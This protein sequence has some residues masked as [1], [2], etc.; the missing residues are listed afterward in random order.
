M[1]RGKRDA[2]KMKEKELRLALVFYG[3]VSLAIYQHG[4]NIEILN[5]IR[6]SRTYHDRTPLQVK[7]DSGVGSDNGL[8]LSTEAV[9]LDLLRSI[10]ACINL[11]VVVDVISGSS[12]GGISGI[13]LARAI[14]HDLDLTPLTEMWF[15]E[16][17][18]LQLIAPEARPRVWSKW[19]FWPIV[20]PLLNYLGGQGLIRGDADAEIRKRVSTFL[21]SRWFKPPFDGTHFSN[22]LLDGLAAMER[23]RPPGSTL[24][25]PEAR[26]DL[27]ITVTD[28]FGIRQTIF[29]H[30][31]AAIEE[32]EHRSYLQFEVAHSMRGDAISD[33]D[34]DNIAA[35]AFAGRASASYPGAFPPAQLGEI[36]GII[37]ERGLAWP[38]R[39][40]FI[41]HNFSYCSEMEITPESVVLL[42]GSILNNKPIRAA[43]SA[44][45]RHPAYREVDRRVV[46]V[47]P[48]PNPPSK[49]LFGGS[50]GFFATLRGALSDLPRYDPI[51]EELRETNQ[52]NEHV[53]RLKDMIRISRPQVESLIEQATEGRHAGE[54]T[55]EQLRKWRVTS[56]NL[57]AQTAIV[58]N[59]WVRAL[60]LESV[61]FVAEL[62]IRACRYPAQSQRARWLRNVVE[63]WCGRQGMFP[64]NYNIPASTAADADL[65]IFGRF[66][67]DFGFKYKKRRLT[68]ILQDINRLYS[69]ID[70]MEKCGTTSAQLDALKR[71]VNELVSDLSRY[72]GADFLS[73]ELSM[74]IVRLFGSNTVDES[75]DPHLFVVQYEPAIM[76]VIDGLV[77]ECALA[78]ANEALDK[79]IAS[80]IIG[81]MG[82]QC[83][84]IVLTGYL[85]FPYWD[86][87]L[88]PTMNALGLETSSFEEILIDRISPIDASSLHLGNRADR[89]QGDAIVGFGGFLSRRARE[90]DYFWGRL[91]AV[92]RLIDIVVSTDRGLAAKIP[93]IRQFK[94]RAFEAVLREEEGHL[95]HISETVKAVTAAV[96]NL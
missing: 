85:G 24:L 41:S 74:A 93:D 43:I 52:F 84:K 95:S 17:D 81:G 9:Y 2:R 47:D 91:H 7:A 1:I 86:V 59:A 6:A 77:K 23:N 30:D 8:D 87:I 79:L 51:Y 4:I 34:A 53:K 94:K 36:D 56:T 58:Y 50:P 73:E 22:L 45:R 49:P 67:V 26:L 13:A 14:A 54:I 64:E 33:F 96:R 55:L 78:E 27:L 11:R 19:Y 70:F 60:V 38:S 65:P 16:A 3:G 40:R 62:M 76:T 89:L 31:P 20:R 88:L 25:P 37:A 83:R 82:A 10:G 18:V 61:D 69:E 12:A 72:E 28:Y 75:S 39:S 42:D 71:S 32:R 63:I 44:I 35:L 15:S 21:R 29:L 90:H 5:L 80:P 46:Y 68:F 48:H 57:L 66:I 92:E